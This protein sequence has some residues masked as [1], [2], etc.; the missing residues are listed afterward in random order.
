[1]QT[2][3]E[4]IEMGKI[5]SVQDI[6][7]IPVTKLYSVNYE[8]SLWVKISD[9]EITFEELYENETAFNS[10]IITQVIHLNYLRKN[11]ETLI[12]HLDHEFVFYSKSDYEKRKTNSDIKGNK[13]SRLK[14]FKIDK[15]N[16]PLTLPIKRNLNLY[17]EASGEI[18]HKEETVPFIIYILKCYLKHTDLIDE[19]FS[20]L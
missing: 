12:T 3:S 7:E 14:S 20:K 13:Y 19:Y 6:G 16:I 8:D 4:S 10:S 5:F 9:S 17:N 18:S 11:T 1:M 2:I 15:A